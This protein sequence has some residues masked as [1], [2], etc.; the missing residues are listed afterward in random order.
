VGVLQLTATRSP[1][2][3]IFGS[4]RPAWE[5]AEYAVAFQI[6]RQLAVAGFT[7]CNGG[8]GG[9]MEAS[10][11]GAKEAGGHTIGIIT[12]S[13]ARSSANRW[14][15]EV[16]TEKSMIDRLMKLV[17]V[18]DAYVVLKGGTGTLLE[19]AAVWELM[20]KD[21]IQKKPFVAVGDFWKVLI[22]TLKDELAWEGLEYAARLITIADSPVECV[23]F[24]KKALNPSIQQH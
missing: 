19:L 24:L 16:I 8:Y 23:A 11:R 6:G 7:V 9:I 22:N 3:S 14:I 15:D 2:I 13:F 12:S 10:A 20:N 18:A 17:S 5:E 1:V 21:A 4:S